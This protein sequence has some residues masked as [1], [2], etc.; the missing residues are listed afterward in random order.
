MIRALS[1]EAAAWVHEA[2]CMAVCVGAPVAVVFACW[3]L[4]GG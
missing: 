2:V 4:M 3:V 1:E